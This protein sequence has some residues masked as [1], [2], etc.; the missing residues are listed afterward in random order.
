MPYRDAST[1]TSIAVSRPA[2]REIS[3]EDLR[4]ALRRGLDDFMAMPSHLL[5][6]GLFYPLFGLV[7]GALTF[8][9][10]GIALLFPLVAG[11][12]LVGPVLATPFYEASRRRELGLEPSWRE[13]LE[14]FSSSAIWSL[15]VLGILLMIIFIAWMVTAQA[16]Y[17]GIYGP[18]APDGV[19]AFLTD[20]LTSYRGWSL[21]LLGHVVGFLFAVVA[22]TISVVSFPLLV[23]RD[24]GAGVALR[25][26]VEAVVAN[27]GTMAIWGLIVAVLL[28]IGSLPLLVGLT[29]VMPILGHSTW[30]L[31]RR[32]ID[33]ASVKHTARRV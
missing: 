19:W 5:F 2:V 10:S 31:Y 6:L 28:A 12:A 25:T 22:F 7:L 14:I 11:F 3:L 17:T 23:D 9:D 18:R 27:P 26:S 33:Q 29:V 16:I 4:I 15:A 24:V 21:I 13:V 1:H 30:H 8:T 20:V 32:T